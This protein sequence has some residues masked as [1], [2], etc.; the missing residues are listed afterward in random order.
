MSRKILLL[1]LSLFLAACGYSVPEPKPYLMPGIDRAGYAADLVIASQPTQDALAEVAK[2]GFKTVISTRGVDE[3]D[4]D[5]AGLVEQLGMRY[6]SIPMGRPLNEISDDQV[7]QLDQALKEADGPVF[8][9]CGSGNRAAGL[10]TAWLVENKGMEQR[11]AMRLG[12]LMGMTSVIP[13]VEK[14][15][16]VNAQ[17]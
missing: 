13:L 1:S 3:L 4:W 14:R 9:H 12:R 2:K 8:L 10:W 16:G 11:E 5:E 17:P 6:V 7:A 15:L